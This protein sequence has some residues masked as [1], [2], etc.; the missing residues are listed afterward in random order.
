MI[1]QCAVR[2]DITVD[3]SSDGQC[4][5]P[6]STL[7]DG[8]ICSTMLPIST[9]TRLRNTFPKSKYKSSKHTQAF[10]VTQFTLISIYIN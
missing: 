2:Q 1:V 10:H 3:I 8:F 6:S 5:H 9:Y 7:L 4:V